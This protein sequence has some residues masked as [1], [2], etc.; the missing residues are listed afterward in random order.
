MTKSDSKPPRMRP[1]IRVLL[2][3]SLALNLAVA[4]LAIGS[5]I[6]FG[7]DRPDRAR[8]PMPL[9]ALMYRALPREDRDMLR[10][11]DRMTREEHEARRKSEA[12]ELD[13]ALRAVPFD[14]AEVEAFVRRDAERRQNFDRE[15]REAWMARIIGMSDAERANYA[16]RLQQALTAQA[17]HPGP[18]PHDKKD[19]D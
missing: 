13:A 5:A 15:M 9:G 11:R 18:P 12:A 8:P 14:P 10:Q 16:D 6:R 2:G 4:G 1:W 19:R 17:R 3:A 7:G